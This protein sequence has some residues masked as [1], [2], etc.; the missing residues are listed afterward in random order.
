MITSLLC[1]YFIQANQE[2]EGEKSQHNIAELTKRLGEGEKKIKQLTLESTELQK[3]VH[4]GGNNNTGSDIHRTCVIT[5]VLL[6]LGVAS[7]SVYHCE[8]L[9]K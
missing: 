2:L 6:T 4:R 1:I 5:H 8:H 3:Q 9:V 7:Q